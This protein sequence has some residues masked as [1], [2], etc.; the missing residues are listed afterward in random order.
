[1]SDRRYFIVSLNR[2]DL[3]TLGSL[4]LSCLG[5]VSALQ[6]MLT[7]AVALM[8]LAMLVDMADGLLARRLKLESEF[9]K[10]LDSFCDVFAYLILPALILF[11]L[12]MQDLLSACALFVFLVA[13]VLRLS[14]F[15][16]LGTVE[17]GGV[18]YHVGLQVI[19]SQLFVVLAFPV[20][21]SLGAS[22]R[23]P[24]SLIL[25][26]MAVFMVRNL[27]FP[28]PTRYVLQTILILAVAAGYLYLHFVGI[29][30]P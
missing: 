9:G 10:Y 28:K 11:Q 7:L 17:E 29:H 12:G 16:I 1:M 3:L 13:G 23:Y 6:R 15:N 30:T 20:W 18:K 5:L 14:R 21:H 25:L 2:V 26:V 22:A 27:R 19:W 4:L 8:L 24:L